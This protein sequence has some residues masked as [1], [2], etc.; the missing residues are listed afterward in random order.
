MSVNGQIPITGPDG[1]PTLAFIQ[2]WQNLQRRVETAEAKL[3]AIAD[4]TAPSGG[5]TIDTQA[6]TAINAILAATS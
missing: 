2:Q 3:T 6:R 5:G 4:I 1:R